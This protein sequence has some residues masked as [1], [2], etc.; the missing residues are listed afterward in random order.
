[1]K[2]KSMFSETQGFLS[3]W[4]MVGLLLVV[5]LFLLYRGTAAEWHA[6]NLVGMIILVTIVLLLFSVR[7]RTHI[8]RAGVHVDFRP[9]VWNQTWRWEDIESIHVKKY[10]FWDYGGWG[11][12]IGR[13]GMAY[14]TKGLYGFQVTFKNGKKIMVGTQKPDV[15]REILN[16][17]Q[18]GNG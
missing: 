9:F 17:K 12:R 11:Y 6:R 3:N 10:S 18:D 7:L 5:L 16:K 13:S 1:M 14:T 8:D 2:N 15:V 4:M